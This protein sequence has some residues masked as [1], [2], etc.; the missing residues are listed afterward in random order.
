MRI[1]WIS[2]FSLLAIALA[3]CGALQVNTEDP[4]ALTPSNPN[5]GGSHSTPSPGIPK[6][7]D[8][9]P[10]DPPLPIPTNPG[11]P[12]LI[13]KAKADLAQRLSISMPQIKAIETKEVFWPDA[14]LGC[15]QPDIVYAQIPS[16]GYLVLLVYA[17]NEFEYHVDIHGNIHYCENPTPPIAGT[18]ADIDPFSTPPP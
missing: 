17:G 13:E 12:A 8:D 5:E 11:L 9:M 16:P 4:S 18:P 2:W 7:E 6:Q 15:P 14:S 1:H 10:K 3:G